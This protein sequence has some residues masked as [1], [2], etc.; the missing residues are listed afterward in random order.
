MKI[1]ILFKGVENVCGAQEEIRPC[2]KWGIS[3]NTLIISN[4]NREY[5]YDAKDIIYIE[6]QRDNN[7]NITQKIK[8]FIDEQINTSE[9][10]NREEDKL[11]NEIIKDKIY[12]LRTIKSMLNELDNNTLQ[13]V[14]KT[15][16]FY[17][18]AKNSNMESVKTDAVI[19][20]LENMKR[21]LGYDR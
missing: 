2:D 7:K 15:L 8:E 19:I 13:Q 1:K 3:G 14:N 16:N 9:V 5:F 20:D 11:I 4:G 10:S 17:K 12:K 6:E 18:T 21:G